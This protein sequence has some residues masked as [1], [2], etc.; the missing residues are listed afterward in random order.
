MRFVFPNFM[1]F[2]EFAR[3]K[4]G[5]HRTGTCG[6]L[7]VLLALHTLYPDRYPLTGDALDAL[8]LDMQA[9]GLLMNAN[10][11]TNVGEL[12]QY[13]TH[14][15]VPHTTIS[16]ALFAEHSKPD[17]DPTKAYAGLH[18]RLKALAG[19]QP[20]MVLVEWQGA[21]IGANGLH[22]DEENVR[23]H[24]SIFGGIDT[25]AAGK[26]A[27]G[28]YLRGDGDSNTDSLTA[29]TE[30]IL[31]GWANEI[32][33]AEP[34]AYIV[35]PPLAHITPPPP[36]PP[37]HARRV[38]VPAGWH[39]DGATLSSPNGVGVAGDFRAFLL[40]YPG[41]WPAEDAILLPETQ[42]PQVERAHPELGGGSVV[43]TVHTQLAKTATHG[44]FVTETGRE[45]L[46]TEQ[47]AGVITQQL[48]AAQNRITKALGDLMTPAH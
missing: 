32:V 15:G 4:A 12:D 46:A 20:A 35:I 45:L 48:G 7:A 18:S 23:F 44:V 42:T 34:I 41:G 31:T 10:G 19:P 11:E 40:S 37:P 16:Y 3:N 47:A 6:P 13:L 29:A 2:S 38:G 26:P 5:K 17:P 9:H 1:S 25:G 27:T 28:G 36:P 33:P 14:L 21:H 22:D 8:V 24:Y 43:I 30:P 39:D